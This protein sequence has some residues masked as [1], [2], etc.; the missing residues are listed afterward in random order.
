M[1]NAKRNHPIRSS[2][3]D[4]GWPSTMNTLPSVCTAPAVAPA[5]TAATHH[6][7]RSDARPKPIAA[8]PMSGND[9][10]KMIRCV[11]VRS[12]IDPMSGAR[13]WPAKKA[14]ST[15]ATA[16]G[17]REVTVSGI[18]SGTIPLTSRPARA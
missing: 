8:A 15:T 16:T 6:P 13:S 14:A 3:S 5:T 12:A 4:F 18:S 11:P 1:P 17:P 2:H 7:G 10:R 9:P